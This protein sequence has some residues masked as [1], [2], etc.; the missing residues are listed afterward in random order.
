M[1][2]GAYEVNQAMMDRLM[3]NPLVGHASNLGAPDCP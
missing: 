2:S 1:K 3:H